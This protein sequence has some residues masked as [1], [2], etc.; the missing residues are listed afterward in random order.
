MSSSDTYEYRSV[1]IRMVAQVVDFVALFVVGYL[2]AM[3]S[4]G[5][6]S[7]GFSLSGGPA[8]LWFAVSMGYFIVLEGT[9]GQTVGKRL[10]GIVV[11]TESGESI[12][13]TDSLVRNLLRVVDGLFFYAV[14]IFLI[15]RSDRKQRF[16]DR[17]ADTVVVSVESGATDLQKDEAAAS[18]EPKSIDEAR[19]S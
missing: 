16:G 1:G 17:V 7:S 4:G 15:F 9:N 2:I 19:P 6:S 18:D 8:F 13:V 11:R 3:T 5:T 10:T 12:T 14:G